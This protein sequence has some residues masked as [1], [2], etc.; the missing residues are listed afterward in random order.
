M[1]L[2]RKIKLL[3]TFDYYV[4][5]Q[6]TGKPKEFAQKL[7]ISESS[8]YRLIKDVRFLGAEVE[9]NYRIE[10]YVYKVPGSIFIGFEHF[11]P[12]PCKVY[13]MQ[14]NNELHE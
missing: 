8:L 4:R 2:I 6:S 11:V 7:G 13:N 5:D 10:S 12:P 1:D 9:F 14:N 3:R